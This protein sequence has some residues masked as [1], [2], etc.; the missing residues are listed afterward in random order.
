MFGA[1]SRVPLDVIFPLPEGEVAQWPQ[2]AKDQQKR[3]QEV[4][5]FMRQNQEVA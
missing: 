1:D 4:Y 5:A 2:F 3:L